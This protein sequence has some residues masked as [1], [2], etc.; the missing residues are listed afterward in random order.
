MSKP[1]RQEDVDPYYIRFHTAVRDEETLDA[2]VA[3][4]IARFAAEGLRTVLLAEQES[5]AYLIHCIAVRLLKGQIPDPVSKQIDSKTLDGLKVVTVR[6][7][8]IEPLGISF[9]KPRY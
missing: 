2:M 9:G 1:W 6:E 3:P 7:A 8:E 5:D 4:S